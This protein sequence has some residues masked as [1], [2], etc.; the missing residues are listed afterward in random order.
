MSLENSK[1]QQL[2][3]NKVYNASNVCRRCVSGDQLS[4]LSS[5]WLILF[6][7]V[8]DTNVD[9][10]VSCWFGAEIVHFYAE[11]E[12]KCSDMF[13][14]ASLVANFGVDQALS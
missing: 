14:S 3:P 7:A 6:V 1:H 5:V 13:S 12:A 9:H 2:F 10:P 4:V 11:Q 8:I